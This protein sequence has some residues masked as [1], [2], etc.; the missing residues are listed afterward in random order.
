M[1]EHG[2]LD[3]PGD[4]AFLHHDPLVV[5][6][7]GRQPHA[8]LVDV[9]GLRLL[10]YRTEGPLLSSVGQRIDHVAF[11]CANLYDA[12]AYFKERSVHVVSGPAVAQGILSAIIAGPDQ[13]A[14]E[15]VEVPR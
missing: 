9:G 2:D 1:P 7:G 10:V 15:L 13:I 8:E 12:L 5:L 3:L 6:E 4:H 11:A 14:I